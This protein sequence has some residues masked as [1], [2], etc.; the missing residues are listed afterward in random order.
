MSDVVDA[1]V[2][3]NKIKFHFTISGIRIDSQESLYELSTLDG[4]HSLGIGDTL[5]LFMVQLV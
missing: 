5:R 3:F 1:E 2:K 4:C